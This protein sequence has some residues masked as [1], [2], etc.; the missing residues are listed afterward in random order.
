MVEK[1]DSV[2]VWII[3]KKKF[4]NSIFEVQL[5]DRIVTRDS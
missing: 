2:M 4:G 5:H 3:A 1:Q